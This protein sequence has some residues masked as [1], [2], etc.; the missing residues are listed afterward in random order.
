MIFMGYRVCFRPSSGVP[1]FQI[2]EVFTEEGIIKH[3]SQTPVTPFGDDFEEIYTDLK[4][5]MD[6]IDQ[7]PLDL[8]MVDRE[9][10]RRKRNES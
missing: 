4:R 6:C 8:D 1:T 3:Y 2:H 5:M 9:I 10:K 7:P